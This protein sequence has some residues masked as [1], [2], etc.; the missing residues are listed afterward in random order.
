[1]SSSPVSFQEVLTEEL[2]TIHERRT[3]SEF[4]NPPEPAEEEPDAQERARRMDLIGLALSGGGI[5]S[6]LFNLGFLQALY[7]QGF[8]RHV[9]Y[10]SSVSGG[11]YIA[12]WLANLM[13]HK[14]D[15]NPQDP[16]PNDQHVP[17]LANPTRLF[18]FEGRYL[19]KDWFTAAG[20]FI[21]QVVYRLTFVNTLVAIGAVVLAW[22][23]RLFDKE[24]VRQ[25][26]A[27]FQCESDLG[28]LVISSMLLFLLLCAAVSFL[29]PLFKKH[30]D[31]IL[32]EFTGSIFLAPLG[33]TSV[34]AFVVALGNA[35]FFLWPSSSGNLVRIQSQQS[36]VL[37]SIVL[38]LIAI[39]L[40]S[41]RAKLLRSDR[42]N[43]TMWQKLMLSIITKVSLYGSFLIV[44]WVFVREDVSR[45]IQTR[46]P[47]LSRHDVWSAGTL[48][49]WFQNL[50]N[51]MSQHLDT[52]WLTQDSDWKGLLRELNRLQ[53]SVAR[54][55]EAQYILNQPNLDAGNSTPWTR[56]RAFLFRNGYRLQQI[57]CYTWSPI[58]S[59]NLFLYW[60][61][62]D[63]VCHGLDKVTCRINS[64]LDIKERPESDQPLY[65]SPKGACFAK[66]LHKSLISRKTL[67]VVPDVVRPLGDGDT[68]T[69]LVIERAIF[70]YDP[71]KNNNLEL[72][73]ITHRQWCEFNRG[74][75]W[76][77]KQGAIKS[78]HL[79]STPTVIDADQWQRIEYLLLSLIALSVVLIWRTFCRNPHALRGFR[80]HYQRSLIRTFLRP[81]TPADTEA[82]SYKSRPLDKIT[83]WLMG[84]PY[85]LFIGGL[86]LIGEKVR[87]FE[88]IPENEKDQTIILDKSREN[89]VAVG[90]PDARWFSFLMSPLFTG[91]HTGSDPHHDFKSREYRTYSSTEHYHPGTSTSSLT[92]GD[93]VA[94]SGAALSPWMTNSFELFVI[95]YLW[96]VDLGQF[97]RNPAL[98]EAKRRWL[99]LIDLVWNHV[100]KPLEGDRDRSI[101][102]LTD[103]KYGVLADGGFREF[104]GAEELLLRRCKLVI[105]SD[106]GCNNDLYEFGALSDFIRLMRVDHGIEVLDLDHDL[107]LD[108]DR[109]RRVGQEIKHST[110]HFI[111]GRIKYPRLAPEDRTIP[112]A[113]EYGLLVYAQMSLTGD[114]DVDLEQFRNLNPNFPD[115]PT[116]NQAYNVDQVVSYIQL[117]EHIGKQLCQRLDTALGVESTKLGEIVNALVASYLLECRAEETISRDDAGPDWPVYSLNDS[118][119]SRTLECQLSKAETNGVIY[120]RVAE[121]VSRLLD[122]EISNEFWDRDWLRNGHQGWSWSVCVPKSNNQ[123]LLLFELDLINII[124]ECN[125]RRA[126][127][128]LR[129]PERFFR[130]GGRKL[131][132]HQVGRFLQEIQKNA[133]SASPFGA[134][135]FDWSLLGL[136]AINSARGVFRKEGV[137]STMDAL[138]CIGSL[139]SMRSET[140]FT[141]ASDRLQRFRAFHREGGENGRLKLRRAIA[142]GDRI[143]IE[144]YCQEWFNAS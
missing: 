98:P 141:Q 94:V 91:W 101:R 1:M 78:P 15:E 53:K 65:V 139:Y 44:F 55:N 63:D 73:G 29:R 11:G 100:R 16:K 36:L 23:F 123:N 96:C 84:F 27:I 42:V 111:L 74:L 3:R 38:V 62:Q 129:N 72:P 97:V 119:L 48:T 32:K 28:S 144:K 116:T 108:V 125:R 12:G 21:F 127:F 121:L 31:S 68:K 71:S 87:A 92:I 66:F 99:F 19:S 142:E 56:V 80:A 90:G 81:W 33:F 117:G 106:A 41:R 60:K 5:R 45:V 89:E 93:A 105:I 85:P 59:P 143:A 37:P 131:L 8:L 135:N 30:R 17:E 40:S 130:V 132:V 114:E 10:I 13:T 136:L 52:K 82:G 51:E 26:L 6:A 22:Y 70:Q 46:H 128:R 14:A 86:R 77:L 34:L 2:R 134:N 103:W 133:C 9:D 102:G 75:L 47:S 25:F 109:L 104:F 138:W 35:D 7:N 24:I 124:I 120:H 137:R 107:P 88:K 118:A 122:L 113:D 57:G 54:L 18:Q 83:P 76:Q 95:L 79:V 112:N 61:S 140:V 20:D 58:S 4:K 50:S 67:S 69:E 64:L 39:A 126:G 49:L 43:A 110:Q 115:E